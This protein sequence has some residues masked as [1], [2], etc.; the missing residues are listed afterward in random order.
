M[1]NESPLFDELPYTSMILQQRNLKQ[2]TDETRNRTNH[3]R[4]MSLQ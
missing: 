1:E 3:N 2:H 4:T